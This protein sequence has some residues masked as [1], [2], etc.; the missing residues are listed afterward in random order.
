MWSSDELAF[1]AAIHADPGDD[2]PRLVYADWLQENGQ[3]ELAEFIR[4]QCADAP[5]ID[6]YPIGRESARERSLERQ[7][8]VRWRGHRM[9]HMRRLP[10]GFVFKRFHRGL[11]VVLFGVDNYA[12]GMARLDTALA[13]VEPRYQVMLEMT[14]YL[15]S[16][17][18]VTPL[19]THPLVSRA[20]FV[21]IK[22]SDLV[23]GR[24]DRG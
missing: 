13:H 20:C 24:F 3:P 17:I 1:L 9:D 11:P 23:N 5:E 4:L 10:G 6:L 18:Q 22:A 14:L 12:T 21:A 7:F 16:S 8:G 2:T 15:N 19:L